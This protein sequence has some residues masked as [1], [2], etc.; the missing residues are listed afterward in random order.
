MVDAFEQSEEI[1]NLINI[2][3]KIDFYKINP[4]KAKIGKSKREQLFSMYV[5]DYTFGLGLRDLGRE[6]IKQSG[7]S[8]EIVVKVGRFD[9]LYHNSTEQNLDYLKREVYKGNIYA[10]KWCPR[11]NSKDRKYAKMLCKRWGLSEKQYRKLIKV[12]TTESLLSEKRID[13]INI[14]KVPY[15]AKQ[16]YAKCFKKHGLVKN[17]AKNTKKGPSKKNIYNIFKDKNSIDTELRKY[18]NKLKKFS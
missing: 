3:K 6:L 14:N 15:L 7:V 9:D 18:L 12:T 10:K 5:R 13:D 4:D 8:P 11:L 1:K 17:S 16:K 2:V